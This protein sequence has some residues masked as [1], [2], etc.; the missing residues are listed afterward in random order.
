MLRQPCLADSLET[1]TSLQMIIPTADYQV[2]WQGLGFDGKKQY[3]SRNG[4]TYPQELWGAF[5]II[6]FFIC[7]TLPPPAV[8]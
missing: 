6:N 4:R 7:L 5:N 1:L 3:R 8:A 2:S